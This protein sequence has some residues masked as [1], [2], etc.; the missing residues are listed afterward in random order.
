MKARCSAWLTEE[1]G[2]YREANMGGMMGASGQAR[3][4]CLYF[5]QVASGDTA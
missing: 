3:L 1:C 2:Q 4:G 5:S